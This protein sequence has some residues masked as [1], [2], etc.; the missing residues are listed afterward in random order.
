MTGTG[1]DVIVDVASK[2]LKDE[3]PALHER[4]ALRVPGEAEKRLGQAV[5]AA[6]LPVIRK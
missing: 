4:I 6:S 5:A 3:F 1:G 2:V